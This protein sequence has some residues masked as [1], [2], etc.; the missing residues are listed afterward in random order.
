MKTL[1]SQSRPSLQVS[2][3]LSSVSTVVPLQLLIEV[4]IALVNIVDVFIFHV[5]ASPRELATLRYLLLDL[6]RH[7]LLLLLGCKVSEQIRV[8]LEL[9]LNLLGPLR[10]RTV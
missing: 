2:F 10:V 6:V 7:P 8:S 4:T 1:P 5:H 3:D 9:T